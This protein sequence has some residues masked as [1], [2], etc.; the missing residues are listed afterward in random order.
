[1][2]D[3]VASFLIERLVEWDVSRIYGYTGDGINGSPRPRSGT[4][5]PT[6]SRRSGPPWSERR[7]ERSF[8][9][10]D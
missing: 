9:A 3:R 7:R 2:A 10:N 8:R 4:T 6:T 5:L 1:M